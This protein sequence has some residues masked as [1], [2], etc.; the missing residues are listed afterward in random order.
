MTLTALDG[1]PPVMFFRPNRTG[2]I[3]IGNALVLHLTARE[4]KRR[5]YRFGIYLDDITPTS[6]AKMGTDEE[7]KATDESSMRAC[8][9]LGWK[10]DVVLTFSHMLPLRRKLMNFF[11]EQFEKEDWEAALHHLRLPLGFT[12]LILGNEVGIDHLQGKATGPKFLCMELA[13]QAFDHIIDYISWRVPLHIRGMDILSLATFEAVMMPAVLRWL[14][15]HAPEGY[16]GPQY[17]HIPQISGWVGRFNLKNF[18]LHNMQVRDHRNAE[19]TL[20]RDRG[21][22]DIWKF[23]TWAEHLDTPEERRRALEELVLKVPWYPENTL[24]DISYVTR[25]SIN[26]LGE[27]VSGETMASAIR[28]MRYESYQQAAFANMPEPEE[29]PANFEFPIPYG[30]MGEYWK[31]VLG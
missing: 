15:D 5:G 14:G 11:W 4:A 24:A 10:P 23:C 3:H 12:D 7:Q 22:W 30:P 21:A 25:V 31:A 16:A 28:G 20:E 6:M 17:A 13:H 26:L 8:K 29:L 1:K 19:V 9:L 18:P 27:P 2:W